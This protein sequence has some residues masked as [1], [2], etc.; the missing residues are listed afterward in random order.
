[1]INKGYDF[2]IDGILLPIT[3]SYIRTKIGNNNKVVNLLN[4]NE[5]NILKKAKLTEYEFKI[6]V[7]GEDFPAVKQFI[8]PQVIINKLEKLKKEKTTFQFVILKMPYVKNWDSDL[9]VT[10]TLE[11]YEIDEDS[12]NGIDLIIDVRLKQYIDPKAI[13]NNSKVSY[14]KVVSTMDKISNKLSSNKTE[15][16]I[17]KMF[18]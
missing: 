12:E 10:V 1:M 5:L 16:D 2:Y 17:A 6:R 4:G 9:N 3:P 8:K 18:K 11:E 7:P 13:Q 14:G 15:K